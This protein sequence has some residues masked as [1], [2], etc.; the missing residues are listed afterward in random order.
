MTK[1]TA[2]FSI[3]CL[4]VFLL[5]SFKS[6]DEKPKEHVTIFYNSTLKDLSLS[7]SNGT[8]KTLNFQK[9][10]ADG[11]LTQVLKTI[12]DLESQGYK[13]ENYNDSH[14]SYK[15]QIVTVLLSK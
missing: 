10:Q 6:G 3:I 1:K 13:L 5:I 2:T 12:G 15:D 7:Y 4:A 11:D 9:R 8:F 14:L